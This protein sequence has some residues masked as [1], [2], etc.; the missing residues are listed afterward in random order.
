MKYLSEQARQQA[1]DRNS[2]DQA[3]RLLQTG[4]PEQKAAALAVVQGHVTA[5]PI[6]EPDIHECLI[7]ETEFPVNQANARIGCS[8]WVECDDTG[9]PTIF[10]HGHFLLAICSGCLPHVKSYRAKR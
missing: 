5:D 7:C 9:S 1:E 6:N 4:T 8:E 10:E 3:L 2:F